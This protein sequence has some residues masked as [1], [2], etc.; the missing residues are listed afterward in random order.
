MTYNVFDGTLVKL[1]QLQL[2]T[3]QCLLLT[4]FWKSLTPDNLFC[5]FISLFGNNSKLH[6]TILLHDTLLTTQH[7]SAV[8]AVCLEKINK[9]LSDCKEKISRLVCSHF[10]FHLNLPA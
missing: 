9:V 7:I 3:L 8:L 10:V 2:Q 6:L 4:Q 5:C 1:T